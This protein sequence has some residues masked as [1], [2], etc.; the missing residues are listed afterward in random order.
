MWQ[1]ICLS[2]ENLQNYFIAFCIWM[3]QLEICIFVHSSVFFIKI[4]YK[5]FNL[6][7]CVF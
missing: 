4:M 6:I 7:L 2:E 3:L 5:D 1:K